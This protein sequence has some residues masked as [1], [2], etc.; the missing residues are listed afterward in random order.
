MRVELRVTLTQLLIN[1]IDLFVDP[2][3]R[4]AKLVWFRPNHLYKLR[5]ILAADLRETCQ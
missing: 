3:R 2:L 1:L 4:S 5:Y